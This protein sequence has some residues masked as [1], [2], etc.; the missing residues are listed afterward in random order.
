MSNQRSYRSEKNYRK[1]RISNNL[2]NYAH[3]CEQDC[4][5]N[6]WFVY[7]SEI[8]NK[9]WRYTIKYNILWHCPYHV[10]QLESMKDNKIPDPDKK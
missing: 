3:C 8:V 1:R 5:E 2:P 4:K 7:V 10:K 6:I 9:G